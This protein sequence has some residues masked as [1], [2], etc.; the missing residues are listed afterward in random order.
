MTP[1]TAGAEIRQ[2]PSAELSETYNRNFSPETGAANT[3]QK[4]AYVQSNMKKRVTIQDIADELGISRNTVSKAFNNSEGVADATREKILKKAVEMGYKQFSYV[5]MLGGLADP[6]KS[7]TFFSSGIRGE[8]AL[9]TTVFFTSFHFASMMLDRFQRE[10]AQLGY[11]LTIH[12]VEP[13]NLSAG[14]LPVTFI[15][16][17]ATAIICF[18]IFDRDYAEM[19]CGLDIPIL[20]VDGPCKQNGESLPADQLYMD[21]TTGVAKIVSNALRLGKKKIGFIGNYE[22]CESFFERY[23]AF[24]GMMMLAGE[25]VDENFI[26]KENRTPE[27]APLLQNLK[28]LPDLFICANDF[29]ASDALQVFRGMGISVP[30]DV[31]LAGFDDSAES[32]LINPPL[33]TV[34]IN[35]QFMGFSAAQL[36]VSRIEEPD[37][38]CRTVY[39][40]TYPVFRQ[41]AALEI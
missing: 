5:Q 16:E 2:R 10:M 30:E 22:H 19:L 21:N 12:R 3:I 31:M 20:F 6:N 25:P 23:M 4:E 37:L 35:T 34:H 17:R 38:D 41:S 11:T 27:M 39:T 26:I 7:D 32:M 1:Q 33:T 28:K 14:T 8:I 13:E 29:V 36:L 40:E 18:E 15:K 9:L 24:R